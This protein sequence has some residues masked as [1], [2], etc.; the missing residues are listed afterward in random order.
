MLQLIFWNLLRSK[1]EVWIWK[2][3]TFETSFLYYL[4]CASTKFFILGRKIKKKIKT[5]IS[6][7]WWN[8]RLPMLVYVWQLIFWYLLKSKIEVWR[9]KPCTFETSFL[10][11]LH[12]ASTKFFIMSGK[13]KK[14]IKT[15]ICP[16]W[17]KL[18]LPKPCPYVTIDFVISAEIKN[19]SMNM[20]AMQFGTSLLYYLHCASAKF[21][22]MR[23]KSKKKLN[24]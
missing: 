4:H 18:R 6:S 17:W 5:L 12:C 1:I 10:Y 22:I 20:K 7:K 9:W 19:W 11:Y 14:K 8:M 24:T 2:P 13:R 23:R 21:F 15:L 3:C 16:K